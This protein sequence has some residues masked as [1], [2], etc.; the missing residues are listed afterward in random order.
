MGNAYHANRINQYSEQR[1]LKGYNYEDLAY[2]GLQ[3][4]SSADAFDFHYEISEGNFHNWM[5]GISNPKH[6]IMINSILEYL[7][8][9]CKDSG[10]YELLKSR[11]L[12]ILISPAFQQYTG[13]FIHPLIQSWISQ[14]DSNNASIL[15]KATKEILYLLKSKEKFIPFLLKE[16]AGVKKRY[17][18]PNL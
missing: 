7:I 14:I 15:Y 9:T 1:R 4:D 2:L 17:R 8:D 10:K 12:M 11:I 5:Q 6:L 18:C 16:Q 13:D 3:I